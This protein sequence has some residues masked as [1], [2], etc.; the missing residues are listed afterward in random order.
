MTFAPAPIPH[1]R[2]RKI[3]ILGATGSIGSST[4][5]VILGA[6]GSFETVA[7][8]SGRDA[9]NLAR[10]ART[11]GARFAAVADVAAYAALKSELAGSGIRAGAGPE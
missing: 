8:A 9:A 1:A 11:L 5:A 7:V 6:P 2:P 10:V 4:E 3:T